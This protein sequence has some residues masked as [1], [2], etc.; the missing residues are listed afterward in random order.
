[1]VPTDARDAGDACAFFGPLL[2]PSTAD[3]LPDHQILADVPHTTPDWVAALADPT[4]KSRATEIWQAIVRLG[5]A[6]GLLREFK[7]MFDTGRTVRAS[8][9][10]VI[11]EF[12]PEL[13]GLKPFL[14]AIVQWPSESHN[15]T[16]PWNGGSYPHAELD[17]IKRAFPS[18][19]KRDAS[20]LEAARVIPILRRADGEPYWSGITFESSEQE[21]LWKCVWDP[22][23]RNREYQIIRIGEAWMPEYD[24]PVLEALKL[25]HARMA[26]SPALQLSLLTPPIHF[27]GPA[28]PELNAKAKVVCKSIEPE[29]WH[30]DDF[31][32]VI[33][34]K[35]RYTFTPGQRVVVKELWENHRDGGTSVCDRA[36]V[37]LARGDEES[38]GKLRD[39][40]KS[41]KKGSMHPAWGPMIVSASNLQKQCGSRGRT[42][43]NVPAGVNLPA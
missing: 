42:A 5:L 13:H 8:A 35:Q 25:F 17:A 10:T 18:V 2:K 28:R 33:W 43:L 39:V 1:M 32:E 4:S 19:I 21:W 23:A 41:G 11:A 7:W 36:L 31:S 15:A 38:R 27:T 22:K 30:S 14:D 3:E 40:F 26:S 20:I 12:L 16:T 9:Q 24:R 6:L 29:Y 34:G 37:T